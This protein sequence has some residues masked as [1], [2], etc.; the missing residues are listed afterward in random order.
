MCSVVILVLAQI[1]EDV[2]VG[3]VLQ[4]FFLQLEGAA[5]HHAIGHEAALPHWSLLVLAVARFLEAAARMQEVLVK[6]LW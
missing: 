4:L 3:V 5:V 6:L 1:G 2:L